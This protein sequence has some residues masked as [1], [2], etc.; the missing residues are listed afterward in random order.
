METSVQIEERAVRWLAKR[1]SDDWGAS[2]QAALDVWLEQSTAHV[3]A[4]LRLEAAWEEALR[5]KALGAGAQPGVVPSPEEWRQSPFLEPGE[6]E[7]NTIS[8]LREFPS[9]RSRSRAR[10]RALVAS[11]MVAVFVG[12][13]AWYLWPFGSTYHTPI[14]GIASVPM[15]DGSKITLNTDSEVRIDFEDPAQR[16]IELQ[17]GEA[18]FEVAKDPTRPFVVSAGDKRVVAVGTKFSVRRVGKEI[19]VYVTEGKVRVEEAAAQRAGAESHDAGDASGSL[20]GSAQEPD[21]LVVAGHMA[22]TGDASVLVQERSVG[23]VE[24]YLSWR[25][26]YLV[27]RETELAEAIAEFNRYNERQIVIE[28]PQVAVIRLSGKF[29]STNFEAFVRLLEDGFQVRARREEGKIVLTDNRESAS[30]GAVIPP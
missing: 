27:F 21:V 17:K 24:E 7:Q 25:S 3:V 6:A 12:G 10:F 2:D 15:N 9:S 23:E 28:D 4:F 5:L 16:H 13:T 26:G 1:D 19:L 14:G 29:R 20:A 11:L 18:F 30:T 8:A 22:R